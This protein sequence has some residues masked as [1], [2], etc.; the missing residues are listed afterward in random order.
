VNASQSKDQRRDSTKRQRNRRI[1]DRLGQFFD[2]R[3]QNGVFGESANKQ[4]QSQGKRENQIEPCDLFM[5]PEPANHI[6]EKAPFLT[7]M[8]LAKN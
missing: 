1:G 7:K 8:S 4:F 3:L 5:I 6:V 2:R